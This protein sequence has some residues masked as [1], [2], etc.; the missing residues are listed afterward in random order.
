M[1]DAKQKQD[2]PFTV[3]DAAYRPNSLPQEFIKHEVNSLNDWSEWVCPDPKEYFMK[4]CD[5]GLVHEAQFRVV[6]Y[7]KDDNLKMIDNPDI[8]SQFRMRRRT[9]K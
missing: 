1:T 4:C 9:E 6:K 3:K 8:Q 7:D 5:C 2:K